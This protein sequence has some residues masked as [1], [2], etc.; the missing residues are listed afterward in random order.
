MFSTPA[1]GKQTCSNLLSLRST[2]SPQWVPGQLT[3]FCR[4]QTLNKINYIYIFTYINVYINAHTHI[5]VFVCVCMCV[6]LCYFKNTKNLMY[7]TLLFGN[8]RDWLKG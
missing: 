8:Y 7:S 3:I 1:P 5:C 4:T 6:C 2:W